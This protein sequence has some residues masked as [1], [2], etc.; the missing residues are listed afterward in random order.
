MLATAYID[1][2]RGGGGLYNP[3]QESAS[4][5]LSSIDD[6]VNADADVDTDGVNPR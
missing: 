3:H 5:P 2:Y 1:S 6:S 4:F